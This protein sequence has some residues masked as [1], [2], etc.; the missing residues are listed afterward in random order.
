MLFINARTDP[1]NRP[2]GVVSETSLLVQSIRTALD[3][4]GFR[5]DDVMR[6]R[7]YMVD[8]TQYS[9]VRPL[10]AS[11]WGAVFPA[12]TLIQVPA[13]PGGAGIQID[14]IAMAQGNAD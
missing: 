9:V 3:R 11:L 2:K 7:T 5:P 14:M 1:R 4:A 12:S 13:L 10:L 8:L 6:A